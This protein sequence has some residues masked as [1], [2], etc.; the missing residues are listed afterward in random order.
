MNQRTNVY[1]TRASS[2]VW[3]SSLFLNL[4]HV[5]LSFLECCY[6]AVASTFFQMEENDP[7]D[8]YDGPVEVP[9]EIQPPIDAA[10]PVSLGKAVKAY[11]VNYTAHRTFV[12]DS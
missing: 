8:D 3:L 12:D 10:A 1:K 7:D 6:R 4:H 5:A 2:V 11:I 9:A